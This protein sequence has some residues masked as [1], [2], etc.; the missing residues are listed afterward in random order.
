MADRKDGPHIDG[1]P[2]AAMLAA[3]RA[4]VEPLRQQAEIARAAAEAEARKADE[5]VPGG[6]F[7]VGGVLV[8]ANGEPFKGD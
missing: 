2:D 1:P 5:T 3:A 8:N 6:K 4:A 7:L